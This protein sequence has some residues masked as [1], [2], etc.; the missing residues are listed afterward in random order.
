[1]GGI[2]EFLQKKRMETLNQLNLAK[3]QDADTKPKE[4][5]V[6]KMKYEE[7][8]ELDKLIRKAQKLVDES[9]LNIMDLETKI[10]EMDNFLANPQNINNID[11]FANY[12]KLKKDLE[13]EMLQWETYN[14]ELDTLKA[15]KE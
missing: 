11:F 14:Q 5:S 2:M 12:E 1:M 3:K 7:R 8:K 4:L 15:E 6:N 9:E 10:E 13:K